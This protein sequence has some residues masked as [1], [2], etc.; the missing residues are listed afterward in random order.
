MEKIIW[1]DWAVKDVQIIY[2]YIS[3]DSKYYASK[4]LDKIN[5]RIVALSFHPYIGRVVPERENRN[6]REVIEGNYRIMYRIATNHILIYRII[7]SARNF[8]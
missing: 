1:S 6:I 3:A 2:Q 5:D 8:R 7:H 4:W